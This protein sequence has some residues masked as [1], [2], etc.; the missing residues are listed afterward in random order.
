MKQTYDV[1]RNGKKIATGVPTP[2]PNIGPRSTPDSAALA[3]AAVTTLGDGTKL[4]A[5]QRDDA[6]FVDLGSIFDLGGLR[7]FNAAHVLP[8]ATDTGHDGVSGFNTNS[9]A[10]KV[11][12]QKLTKDHA[13]PTGPNDPDAVLGVWAAASRKQNRIDPGRRHH[14]DQRPVEA[15]LAAR[16]PADQRGRHPDRQEGLLEQPEARQGLAVREVLPEPGADGRRQLP[17]LG[18]DHRSGRHVE[19]R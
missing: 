1:Y 2:P 5:G 6:F 18:R 10:I 7:P 13:L 3:A 14:Q 4:F 16:Q 19:P 8:L 17:V 9:I 15:G 11:P 12:L